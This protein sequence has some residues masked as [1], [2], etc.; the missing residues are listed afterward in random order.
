M[1]STCRELVLVCL[2]VTKDADLA[3]RLIYLRLMKVFENKSS[4]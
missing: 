2:L 1:Q 4:L 3:K